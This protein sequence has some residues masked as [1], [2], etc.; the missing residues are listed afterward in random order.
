MLTNGFRMC[1][2]GCSALFGSF[3]F[4]NVVETR[5]VYSCFDAFRQGQMNKEE[6]C[7]LE[8]CESCRRLKRSLTCILHETSLLNFIEEEA[9]AGKEPPFLRVAYSPVGMPSGR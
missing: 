9:R 2:N 3:S 4:V 5:A 8:L 1:L 6:S 7:E